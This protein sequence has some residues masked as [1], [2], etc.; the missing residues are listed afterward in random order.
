MT[1]KRAFAYF[2]D[3]QDVVESFKKSVRKVWHLQHDV[4]CNSRFGKVDESTYDI[5]EEEVCGIIEG[6]LERLECIFLDLD[7]SGNAENGNANEERDL[8]GFLLG[9][10]IR[11]RWP[12]L[13]IIIVS[14]F[15]EKEIIRKGLLFDFDDVREGIALTQLDLAGFNGMLD[16]A[17]RKRQNVIEGFGDVPVAFLTGKNKFF[18]RTTINRPT[19]EYAFAAMPFDTNVV[20]NDVWKFGI[21]GAMKEVEVEVCRADMDLASRPI[22]DKVATYIFD[23]AFV[24]ADLTGW[25]ANVLYE[26]GLAHASNKDCILIYNA[27]DVSLIPFDVRHIAA[28]KYDP[29]DIESLKKDLSSAVKDLLQE[30]R[31]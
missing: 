26:L 14:R 29:S 28:I 18:R 3:S 20:S 17:K 7:F 10:E 11:Q 21:E 23:S 9:R 22:M 8:V 4:L 27:N 6:S 25:N 24:I 19:K 2:D 30:R 5:F 12:Q 16:L 15:T 31:D 13:P 1:D